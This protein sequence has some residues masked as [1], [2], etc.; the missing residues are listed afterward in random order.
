MNS[1]S[2]SLVTQNI[3]ENVRNEVRFEILRR[4]RQGPR[5]IMSMVHGRFSME[6]RILTLFFEFF[7]KY[8]KKIGTKSRDDHGGST[9][10]Q[11]P[12]L[13]L[14]SHTAGRMFCLL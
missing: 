13:A 6:I 8:T 2:K 7:Q 9:S 1:G 10:T 4:M 11:A 3:I 5:S 12:F 14:N